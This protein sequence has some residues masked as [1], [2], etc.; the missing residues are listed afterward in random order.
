MTGSGWPIRMRDWF[1]R[2]S[3]AK[4]FYEWNEGIFVLTNIEI[5]RAFQE[6]LVW[7]Y[8]RYIYCSR[9]FFIV[10]MQSKLRRNV[11]NN[12]SFH[13]LMEVCIISRRF[14]LLF[15]FIWD[16]MIVE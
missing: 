11:V 8:M 14:T 15:G 7:S 4:D 12:R 6:I 1:S 2:K 16:K 5:T 13:C 10:H 9:R 3:T